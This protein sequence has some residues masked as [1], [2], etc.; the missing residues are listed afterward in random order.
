MGLTKPKS[1]NIDTSKW[2]IGDPIVE[3]NVNLADT[4]PNN[5]DIGFIFKRGTTG[6][7][8]ALLWDKSAQEFIFAITSAT[9]DSIGD[10]AITAYS[11]LQ[12]K[13]LISAGLHY[14]TADGS[15]GQVIVTDG[16]GNLS[17]SS[18]PM[19]WG[20]ITGTL[21]NQTDL[22]SELDLKFDDSSSVT[23]GIY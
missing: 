14:P 21:S 2:V 5:T 9:G 18:T 1:T 19:V 13:N 3:M 15:N 16:A 20:D 4:N 11:D 17:F 23:G 12:I 22:Q 7:N 10:L 8:T 6:D